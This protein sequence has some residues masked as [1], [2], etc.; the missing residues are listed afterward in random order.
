[1][2]KM[3]FTFSWTNIQKFWTDRKTCLQFINRLELQ[4]LIG[5][6][7]PIQSEYIV[8]ASEVCGAA[9]SGNRERSTD[10]VELYEWRASERVGIGTS[11]GWFESI[12]IWLC[13][14]VNVRRRCVR[15]CLYL[16][17]V[18]ISMR[19]I[20]SKDKSPF[21]FIVWDYI[22]RENVIAISL[23]FLIVSHGF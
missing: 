21:F 14:V 11:R 1:M 20:K 10:P 17:L 6:T 4:I 5:T 18:M 12:F 3:K 7:K 8:A 16:N 19:T 9:N 23:V 15:V 22:V 13:G 2:W